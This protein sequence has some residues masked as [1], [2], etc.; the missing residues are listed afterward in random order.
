MQMLGRYEQTT[1]LSNQN[2]GTCRW[3]FAIRGGREFFIK[4][5]LEPRHPET[6]AVS[7]PEKRERKLKKCQKFEENKSSI[8]RCLNAHSDGNAVRIEEFFRLGAKYYAVMPRIYGEEMTESEIAALPD[9][10]KRR[11]CAVIC[12]ALSGLHEAGFVHSD[13]KATNVLLQKTSGGFLTAKIIDYD[14]GFFED[15][16]PQ[17]A[18]AIEG[19]QV[20]FAPEVCNALMGGPIRLS[21][22]TDIF[23]LGVLLHQ[24]MT[25][26][27]PGFDRQRYTCVG[28]AS[29]QNGDVVISWDMPEDIHRILFQ[30]L[31]KNPDA[32]PSAWEAYLELSKPLMPEQKRVQEM[33]NKQEE[34]SAVVFQG[35]SPA[36]AGWRT[37]GD[38]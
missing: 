16:P 30:M 22:K 29:L 36:Q 12:H 32:R 33:E 3:C 4:E 37:L 38:L 2:A 24:Y 13:I 5:Y 35:D 27:L 1:K 7:S 8:F 26:E 9:I 6:D 23:S 34:N 31:Q 21:C 17:T 19:D 28:E 14:A 15:T 10:Q 25:G 11:I 18:D 20:Y